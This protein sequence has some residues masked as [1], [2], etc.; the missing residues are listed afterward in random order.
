[1]RGYPRVRG[2][3]LPPTQVVAKFIDDNREEFGVESIIR[4]SAATNAEIEL[5]IYYIDR[6]VTRS[7]Q[8]SERR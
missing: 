2:R 6:A 8:G 5:S 4:T 1:M 3:A 7:V